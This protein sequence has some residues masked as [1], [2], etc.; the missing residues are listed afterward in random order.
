MRDF[1]QGQ[2]EAPFNPYVKHADSPLIQTIVQ[3]AGDK[4]DQRRKKPTADYFRRPSFSL[5]TPLNGLP[6][7]F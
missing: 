4:E 5:A 7:L 3:C 1:P 2:F 6:P